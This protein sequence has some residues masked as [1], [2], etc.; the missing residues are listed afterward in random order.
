M[1]RIVKGENKTRDKKGERERWDAKKTRRKMHGGRGEKAT[2]RCGQKIA[3]VRLKYDERF[4][5]V[6]DGRAKLHIQLIPAAATTR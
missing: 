6:S 2:E 1:S 5:R 3:L 4:D